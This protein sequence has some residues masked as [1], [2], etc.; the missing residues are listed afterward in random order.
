MP[1]PN[2]NTLRVLI[3]DDESLIRLGIR[4]AMAGL[5]G[6]EVV[7]ECED[8]KQAVA[9]ILAGG[10]DLVLL[11]VQMPGAT[12]LDVV[13]NVG[14]ERMPMVIFVTAY[15]EYAIQAF[16]MNAVD[17]LLKPFDK[18]RLQRSIQ[19]ARERLASHNQTALID[20]LQ[21]LLDTPK[22]LARPARFVV[23]NG[24]RYDFVA[25]D[26]IDWIESA[27]NYVQL[28]AGEENHLL[29][30]TMTAIEK[31]LDP[32]RFARVHRCHI[33]NLSR[34]VAVY[35]MLHGTWVLELRNGARITTGRQYRATVQELIAT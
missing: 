3:V 4:S 22:A 12:G 2:L 11:D 25:I 23:R 14:V 17:Y 33:V 7:G 31:K 32:A 5:D 30:E 27:N 13:R 10:V 29:A 20:R 1:N 6:I 15:D 21:S 34:I 9:A 35:P 19:R 8:G 28:H 24:D 18:E 26:D 16:D